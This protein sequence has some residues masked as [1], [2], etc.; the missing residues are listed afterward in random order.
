[1]HPHS[2]SN[3]T[4]LLLLCEVAAKPFMEQL[5]ANY[6]A[7]QDCK[8]EGKLYD[9]ILPVSPGCLEPLTIFSLVLLRVS[10]DTKPKSGKTLAKR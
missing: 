3:R 9:H 1:M 5:S 6:N 8:R 2:L 10:V 4:G 7:D